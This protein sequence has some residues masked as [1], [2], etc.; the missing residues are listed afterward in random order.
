VSSAAELINVALGKP[1]EQSSL[2]RWSQ[3][4]ADDA[5]SGQ[6]PSDFAFHTEI[7]ENPWWQV[8]L[9]SV[10]PLE[11]IVVHNR[12]MTEFQN[13]AKTLKIE[14]ADHRNDWMLVHTGF[15]RFGGGGN[16]Y[17][18]EAW[19]GGKLSA[20]YVRISL[21]ERQYLHLAQVEVFARRTTI[22]Q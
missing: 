7:E 2:S 14:V 11:V 10:F 6:F 1:A 18:F 8:D 3:G 15:A 12:V 5:V 13:R 16:G 17:P 4:V 19:L 22:T 20:R 9:G 21:T